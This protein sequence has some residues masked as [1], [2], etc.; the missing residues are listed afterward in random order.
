MPAELPV[1]SSSPNGT[2]VEPGQIEKA[3][4]R[5]W[6]E[7]DGVSTRASLMNLAVYS[8]DPNGLDT[9]SALVSELTRTHACRAI[10]INAHPDAPESRVQSWINVHCHVSRAGAKQVCCEQLSFLLE[11]AATQHIP[12]IVFSHLDS[13]LPLTFCW[14]GNLHSFTDQRFWTWVDK[15][16]VD[17]LNW[18]DPKAELALLRDI[19]KSAPRLCMR[20]INWMRSVYLRGALTQAFDHPAA[21][22]LLD[23]LAEIEIHHTAERRL[24]ALLVLSWMWVRLGWKEVRRD[25]S[26]FVAVT[27]GENP[28]EIK[29]TL[30]AAAG[31]G[32]S[33]MALRSRDSAGEVLIT[34]EPGAEHY[35]TRMRLRGEGT[36]ERLT[37]AGTRGVPALINEELA[38]GSRSRNCEITL[39]R[40]LELL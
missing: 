1:V 16:I 2:P 23:D 21:R 34:R 5:L 26:N 18:T 11:G 20:D 14:L 24:T 29:I 25:G 38:R 30:R 7:S 37:P 35:R 39:G 9:G 33:L 27:E 3:L 15:L 32:F 17:S 31:E 36:T 22:V 8:E 40:T 12:N 19:L 4:K 10:L 28:R 13:D 6:A